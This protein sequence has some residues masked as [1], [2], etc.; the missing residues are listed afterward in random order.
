[1]PKAPTEDQ[2]SRD[3]EPA[4]DFDAVCIARGERF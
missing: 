2:V 1:M 4:E 3:P